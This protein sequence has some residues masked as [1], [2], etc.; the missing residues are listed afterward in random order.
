MTRD[1]AAVAK[2]PSPSITDFFS[3]PRDV[4]YPVVRFAKMRYC[5]EVPPPAILIPAMTSKITVSRDIVVGSRT[6][7]PLILA[8]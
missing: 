8:W 6:Q 4:K 3:P 5:D 1:E 7:I 2:I